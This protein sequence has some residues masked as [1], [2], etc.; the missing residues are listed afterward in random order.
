MEKETQNHSGDK[1]DSH[2]MRKTDWNAVSAIAASISTLLAFGALIITIRYSDRQ[3]QIA[4]K[5]FKNERIAD[6]LFHEKE[7]R[8]TETH[9]LKQMLFDSAVLDSTLFISNRQIEQNEIISDRDLLL[10]REQMGQNQKQFDSSFL[11]TKE[12]ASLAR[13]AVFGVIETDQLREVI[14]HDLQTNIIPNVNKMKDLYKKNMDGEE[15]E[16]IIRPVNDILEGVDPIQLKKT[17]RPVAQE[18]DI[19][20]LRAIYYNI[21]LLASS[22]DLLDAIR[23][24]KKSGNELA[25]EQLKNKIKNRRWLFNKKVD[26][27]NAKVYSEMRNRADSLTKR[28]IVDFLEDNI[29]ACESII[30]N[31]MF[32]VEKYSAIDSSSLSIVSE[33]RSN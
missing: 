5:H 30:E 29:S 17:F 32:I 21:G 16:N 15:Y 1:K 31:S 4:E 26:E 8:M 11:I 12:Q 13:D 23:D 22:Q 27:E 10:Q 7:M 2:K 25:N 9:F 19:V 24:Y 20:R 18:D 28:Y 33:V 14:L 6:S 3:I